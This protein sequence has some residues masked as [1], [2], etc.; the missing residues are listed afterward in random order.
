MK[1]RI[2]MLLSVMLLVVIQATLLTGC[3]EKEQTKNETVA[4]S[5]TTNISIDG[6]INNDIL[7]EA[8]F[9]VATLK[10]G[11]KVSN[12]TVKSIDVK[13]AENGEIISCRIEFDG[14]LMVYGNFEI[15]AS[16]DDVVKTCKLYYTDDIAKFVPH[17]SEFTE[18]EKFLFVDADEMIKLYAQD[19]G[20]AALVM[21]SFIY[22]YD[23]TIGVLQTASIVEK[24]QSDYVI[25]D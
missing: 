10:K 15:I 19:M 11:D 12:F 16:Q 6:N 8:N 13:E 17:A 23:K 1:K 24:A 9:S 21:D 5:A 20:N 4:P 7:S 2:I 3:K 25:I 18:Y 14:K 22:S